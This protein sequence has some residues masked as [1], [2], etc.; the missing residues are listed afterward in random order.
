MKPILFVTSSYK[1]S[2]KLSNNNYEYSYLGQITTQQ[3]KVASILTKL[4]TPGPG[5]LPA[6]R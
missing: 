2:V 3:I 4:Q 1:S 5:F 6:I